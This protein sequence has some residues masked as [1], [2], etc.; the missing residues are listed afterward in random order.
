M[1]SVD[2]EAED[3]ALLPAAD[4]E[5]VVMLCTDVNASPVADAV[6]VSGGSKKIGSIYTS[7]HD[8]FQPAASSLVSR[9]KISEVWLNSSLNVLLVHNMTE[10]PPHLA[11]EW[12]AVAIKNIKC[13]FCLILDGVYTRNS[14]AEAQEPELRYVA[15][16][17]AL[18]SVGGILADL[19]SLEV[20]EIVTSCSAAAVAFF[21][22]CGVPAILLVCQKGLGFSMASSK[23]FT[24]AN[25][26]FASVLGDS[27][28]CT[29]PRAKDYSKYIA[30]DPYL[31]NTGNIYT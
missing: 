4:Q 17:R 8:K 7:L 1:P 15:T 13:R 18:D 27:N 19:Q 28:L 16:S 22:Y 5:Y 31:L 9:V 11:T 14:M 20:G 2:Y 23:C 10:I 3:D 21:E 25:S 12:L 29:P 6:K 26:L 24:K 30:I